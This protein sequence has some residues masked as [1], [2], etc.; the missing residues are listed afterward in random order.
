MTFKHPMITM[1]KVKVVR[2]ENKKITSKRDRPLCVHSKMLG[3]TV[4]KCYKLHGY[5]PEY[6]PRMKAKKI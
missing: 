1:T 5:F 3:H 4:D 2:D 6:K